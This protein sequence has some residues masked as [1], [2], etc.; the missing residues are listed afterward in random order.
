MTTK[1]RDEP[2]GIVRSHDEST[3]YIT[4]EI[5]GSKG[6]IL[7]IS[8]FSSSV[9]RYQFFSFKFHAFRYKAWLA[10]RKS[11]IK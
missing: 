2:R 7:S 3:E 9:W 6:D 4:T 8:P 11:A 5:I 1:R 10:W